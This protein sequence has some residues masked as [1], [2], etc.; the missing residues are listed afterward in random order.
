MKQITK[1]QIVSTGL[2]IFSML[3]GAGNLIYPLMVG[4]ES[5]NLVFFGAAGFLL[6]AVV[7]PVAGLI[8]MILFDGDYRT[9][10]KRLGNGP[11][12]FLIGACMTIIGPI[13]AIPRITTLSHTMVAPFIPFAFL[14]H[15]TIGSSFMFA[16]IFLGI[17]FLATFRESKIIDILGNYIS[18]ALLLSL[19]II[20]VWGLVTAQQPVI[21]TGTA[22]DLFKVNLIRGYETLDLLGGIFFASIIISIL[23]QSVGAGYSPHK[24]AIIGCKAGLIGVSLLGIVYA[25]MSFLGAF[26][27]HGLEYTNAGEL[28][29]GIAFTVLGNHGAAIIATAVLMACLS[30]SIALSA[31]VAE[32]VQKILGN[33]INFVSALLLTLLACLP[34][35]TFGLGHV[36]ALTAGPI[37]YI[38]YPIIIVITFC[39]IAYKLFDFKPIKIPVLITLIATLISYWW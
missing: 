2:A 38:G 4:Q 29:R 39:N 27:S 17:T 31:V 20:I 19:T 30:T 10:F 15:I 36:L 12:E 35:S 3:F 16:L 6:T 9:F 11:G 21:S 5:G 18:P 23:K 7:L 24:L 33:R 28:F 13:I 8:G 32:Y 22:F 25:G 26:H 37:V 14:Q 34:L 1:S